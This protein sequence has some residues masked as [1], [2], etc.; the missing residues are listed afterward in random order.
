MLFGHA[1]F[2]VG[3]TPPSKMERR[4]GQKGANQDGGKRPDHIVQ[5]RRWNQAREHRIGDQHRWEPKH[6]HRA[7]GIEGRDGLDPG[8]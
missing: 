8:K 5:Q 7:K 2:Q 3:P 6:K 4:Q 1:P